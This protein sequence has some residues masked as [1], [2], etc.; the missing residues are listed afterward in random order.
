MIDSL[1]SILNPKVIKTKKNSPGVKKRERIKEI[2]RS[3]MT[4]VVKREDIEE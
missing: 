3:K 2:S 1:P 4:E